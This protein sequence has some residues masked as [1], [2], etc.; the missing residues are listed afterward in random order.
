MYLHPV[1]RIRLLSDSL[2]NQI[3]AGEVIERPSSV[4][5][6]LVENSLDASACHIHVRIAGG[7][8]ELI[9]V[10]DDGVGM[11]RDDAV[12]AIERHATSK[13]SAPEDLQAISTMGFRGEALPSIAAVSEVTIE[14]STT[15][16]EGTR[17]LIGFG[18]IHKVEPCSRPRGTRVIIR[19]LFAQLPARRKFLRS[20]STELRHII[21]V[22]TGLS[23]ANQ[24][25]AFS[26]TSGTRKL[27]DAPQAHDSS[28]R[29]GDL[30]GANRARQAQAVSYQNGDYSVSGFLLPPS[31]SREHVVI[32]NQRLV[33]DRMLS[34]ALNRALRNPDGRFSA[35]AFIHLRMPTQLVDINVHPA[36]AEVR[37]AEPGAAIAVLTQALASARTRLHS[38]Q[39]V[40]MIST[41]ADTSPTPPP[42]LFGDR[43]LDTT[44]RQAPIYN[45]PLA[46]QA[47]VAETAPPSSSSPNS[48]LGQYLG[49]Y[50]GTYL[51]VEDNEGLLLVDQHAAHE[52]VLYEILLAKEKPP[53]VQRLLI[54][55][56]LELSPNSA[57]IAHEAAAELALIGLE[58]EEASGLS[59]RIL[60]VPAQLWSNSPGLLVERLLS[61]LVDNATPGSTLRERAAAS[62]ACQS[63]IK[64]NWSLSQ[65]EAEH[66]L[67]DLL[68]TA[69]PHR[70]P[71][72]RPTMLRLYHSEIEQ[73][74]G[75]K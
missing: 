58:I 39:P 25:V 53:A 27:I 50:R 67:G 5:K 61:D 38:P 66:L 16:G 33:R 15:D 28:Q 46:D 41:T 21:A 75:R 26:L 13:I 48:Q 71:H 56:I 62:L 34:G 11:D 10:V 17:V 45:D 20:E 2:I 69:D 42:L 68:R 63:A 30:V 60:G 72:G 43:Y 59:L 35:E 31:A 14:T 29:L 70:C 52:R 55:E 40:R 54:P 23:F 1:S 73:R 22:I 7:G 12:L 19:D 24:I 3:A 65:V 6:E 8:S 44:P 74:I 47:F 4:V 51:I 64:K 49:Q 57:A 18:R 37:F 9:E 36:K 32:V